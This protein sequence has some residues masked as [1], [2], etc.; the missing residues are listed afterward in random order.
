MKISLDSPPEELYEVQFTVEFRQKY[1]EMSRCFD[2][3]LN[4]GSLGHE[5]RL[6]IENPLCTASCLARFAIFATHAKPF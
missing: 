6:E 5:V 2:N 3:L 4:K 1:A